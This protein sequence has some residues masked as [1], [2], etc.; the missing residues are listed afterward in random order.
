MIECGIYCGDCIEVLK[1]IPDKSIDL[2][3]TDPPYGLGD[4]LCNGGKR[5]GAPT[6][7]NKLYSESSWVD[8]APTQEYFTEIFRVSKNQI[9][10]GGNYF[11]LP[12][13]RGFIVWDKKK[14][15]PNYSKVEYL[16]ASF[17]RPA[18]IFRYCSNGGFIKKPEDVSVHPTQKPLS[19]M[20]WC[21]ENYSKPGDIVL[22][23]FM[24]SGTTVVACKEMG[25]R[26][27][28]IEKEMQYFNIALERLKTVNNTNQDKWFE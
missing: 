2:V 5:R 7:M 21:L 8:V 13:C 20:R 16:W 25:R 28:G 6:T 18:N 19:L 15:L 9:I 12:P 17:D 27:I 11:A 1:D 22:D 14:G 3:L 23:P 4:K 10:C 26:Y 24:G